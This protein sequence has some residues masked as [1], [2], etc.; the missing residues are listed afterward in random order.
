MVV[1]PNS[2]LHEYKIVVNYM[3]TWSKIY[4]SVCVQLYISTQVML[5]NIII[6][7]NKFIQKCKIW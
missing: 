1:G 4:L 3:Y 5:K 6:D 7:R 2:C